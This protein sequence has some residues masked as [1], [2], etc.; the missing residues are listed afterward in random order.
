M[1]IFLCMRVVTYGLWVLIYDLRVLIYGLRMV[2]FL[3]FF[4]VAGVSE[5]LGAER[6]GVRTFS[7]VDVPVDLQVPELGELLPA[8]AAAVRTLPGVSP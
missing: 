3:V 8:D 6:A 4:E 2:S 5:A 1:L 7:G